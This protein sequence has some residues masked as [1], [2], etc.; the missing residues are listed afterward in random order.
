LL[1]L[2]SLSLLRGLGDRDRERDLEE[3][4]IDRWFADS[5][6]S[7]F[8]LDLLSELLLRLLV[9]LCCGELCWGDLVP[10]P[11][12]E[13]LSF[14]ASAG[15]TSTGDKVGILLGTLSSFSVLGDPGNFS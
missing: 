4:F 10:L 7:L 5:L 8:R 1:Y 2:S 14:A 3:V 15:R 11:L 9:P 13:R 12:D 6:L